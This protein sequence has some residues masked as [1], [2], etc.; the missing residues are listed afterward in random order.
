MFGLAQVGRGGVEA[1]KEGGSEGEGEGAREAAA[2]WEADL[3]LMKQ[4]EQLPRERRAWESQATGV[5]GRWSDVFLAS[6]LRIH[7]GLDGIARGPRMGK[8][9]ASGLGTH[10]HA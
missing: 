9:G 8:G 1:G 2:A 5:Q 4:R 3:G 10:T 7:H 6:D